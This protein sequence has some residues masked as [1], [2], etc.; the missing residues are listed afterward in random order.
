MY[1]LFDTSFYWKNCVANHSDILVSKTLPV[2]TKN[3]YEA[4]SAVED[5]ASAFRLFAL[6]AILLLFVYNKVFILL[7]I[8]ALYFPIFGH[9][10]CKQLLTFI[11]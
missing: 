8:K 11:N 3:P 6:L 7:T 2:Q 10:N 5:S 1:I 4:R 9:K